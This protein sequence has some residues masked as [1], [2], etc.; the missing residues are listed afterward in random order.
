ML[1]IFSYN[2]IFV[3]SFEGEQLLYEKACLC[4]A[5]Q[6]NWLFIY[7]VTLNCLVFLP[8][9][10]FFTWSYTRIAIVIWQHQT[11]QAQV[12]NKDSNKNKP[13]VDHHFERKVR[14]FKVVILLLLSFILC[15]LP[16]WI[17]YIIRLASSYSSN[18]MWITHFILISL[19]IL[20]CALNPLLYNFLNE[21]ITVCE[22]FSHF[23]RKFLSFFCCFM[24][25]EF[26][27]L[28]QYNP[29]GMK[30]HKVKNE[31]KN[32]K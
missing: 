7:Y 21:S 14:T 23:I 16:Y 2:P 30:N 25:D 20:N 1:W 22:L 13:V 32:Q 31:L 28:S 8:L 19:S 15:R 29:F 10:I 9:V 24:H 26:E 27:E 17:F 6:K 12:T 3:I 5:V 18:A 4:I 11:P